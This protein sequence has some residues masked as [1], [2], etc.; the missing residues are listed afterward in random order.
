[1]H[2]TIV[3]WGLCAI[4]AFV[5]LPFGSVDPWAIFAFEAATLVLSLVFLAGEFFARRRAGAAA[6]AG[7][8]GPPRFSGPPETGFRAKGEGEAADFGAAGGAVPVVPRAVGLLLAVFL[9]VSIIQ[10]VP[11]PSAV[12]KV[13]SPR[14]ASIYQGMASD[15]L[16]G[17]EARSWWTLSLAPRVSASDLAL[18]VC[19]GLFGFLVLKCARSRRRLEVLVLVMAG[20]ALFQAFYGMAETFSGSE[21]ILGHQ[22][23]YNIGSVTGT[24]INRNHFAGL[25]EMVFPLSL[26]YLLA[27][28]RFFQMEKGLGWRRKLLW[29]SQE[30][31][32]WSLIFGLGS[33]FIGL[34]LVF[35]KSRS[36]VMI[37]LLT[38]VLAAAGFGGWRELSE[39]AEERTRVRGLARVVV[40]GVVAA[41]LWIGIGP[42]LE[43]FG[44]MDV[45]REARRTFIANTFR[46]SGDFLWTG[47]G[48]GTYVNVYPMYKKVDDG[49]TLSY[50]HNDYLEFTAENGLPAGG[51]LIAAGIWLFVRLVGHW[52]KRRNNFA[53]GVGLGAI[54]GILAILIHGFTDFNLQIPANAVYFTAMCALALNVVTKSSLRAGVGS[55]GEAGAGGNAAAGGGEGN[56]AASG[57]AADAG[58]RASRGWTTGAK[59]WKTV[60]A[61]AAVVALLFF[62]AR[63]FLGFRYLGLYREARS[64]ARSVQSAFPE[65]EGL[66][67]KAARFAARPEIVRELGRLEIEM[68]RAENESG[69]GEARDQHCDRAAASYEK[70]LAGDP[71]DSFIQYETGMTYLL[72]N[73]PLMTYADKAGLYFRKALALN[74]ADEFLN[75]NILYYYLT[76]WDGLEEADRA[77]AAGR[78]RAIRAADPAFIPKLA[79]RWKQ[80]F[81]STERLDYI[82]GPHILGSDRP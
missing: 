46:M 75:L 34:A 19:Y 22:K 53:K 15:G 10:I 36:G 79:Q 12:V 54:L 37:F 73:Y 39:G 62:A 18:M 59:L 68:A 61:A 3:F 6:R 38:A 77:Y 24:Y 58:G 63:D 56:M 72:Y 30:N 64:G 28:A 80:S 29:F 66:L 42:V 11:L 70:A 27:K 48:K 16:A 60:V 4:L 78:L 14:A 20:S 8:S 45:S 52:R 44:E 26:G 23:R 1:M 57:A 32:Q 65:L 7:R 74:P 50:A 33:M 49:F 71:I 40:A 25:M 2:K 9:A 51:C 55:G 82:L 47:A 76:A 5:P 31:L 41:A 17:W 13:L 69:K 43:R 81:G 21:R 35:S 67:T